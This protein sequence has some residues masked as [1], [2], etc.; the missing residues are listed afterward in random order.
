MNEQMTDDKRLALNVAK[1]GKCRDTLNEILSDVSDERAKR[2]KAGDF[3]NYET[4]A[5]IAAHLHS[6]LSG[7]EMAC[8]ESFNLKTDQVSPRTGGGGK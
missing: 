5:R 6:T 2:K 4:L 1:L 7:L 3:P 8:A